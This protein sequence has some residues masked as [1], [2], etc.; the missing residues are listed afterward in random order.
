MKRPILAAIVAVVGVIAIGSRAE[1]RTCEELRAVCWTMR[2]EKA[3]CTKPYDDCLKSG[4]FITPLGRAFR[5]T[6][7][8]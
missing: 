3:D 5:A 1:A 2:S 4:V 6:P 7:S 8:K